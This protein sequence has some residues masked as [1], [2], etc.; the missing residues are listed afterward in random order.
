MKILIVGVGYVGLVTGLCLSEF[1]YQIIFVD[2]NKEKLDNLKKSKC[3]FYE[4]GIDQLLDKHL[5]ETKRINFSSNL[6][7]SMK[8]IDIVFISVGT[9]SRRLEDEADLTS[10]F[11]VSKEIA[12]NINNY[13]VIVT[14]STVPVG[15]T[16]KIKEIISQQI[17]KNKFDV[18]SNP[19]FLREGSAIN[20]FMRPDRVIIGTES[21]KSEEVMKEIYRPLFLKETPII[22]TSIETAEIIKYASNS[23]L[24]TKIAFINEVADLCEVSG[25]NVQDV[26]KAMGLDR[27]IGSK[28]L[29]AG[30]GYGGSCF[31][32]DVKAF[33]STALKAGIKLSIVDAVNNSNKLRPIKIANKISNYYN[34]ELK[35]VVLTLLGLS[36]KPNTDDIRDSTSI[37]IAKE[38]INRG[39]IVNAYDPKA[40]YNAQKEINEIKYFDSAYEACYQSNGLII[41]TEWNEFR[42]LD[43]NKIK[44]ILVKPVI[45]DLRNIYS[46][47][48][49][50]LLGIEYFGI[51]S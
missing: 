51:G 38:L 32:K 1:G 31:P 25:A 35:N 26:A 36:F 21:K 33:S 15:T 9:P 17:N 40:K 49:T 11:E 6:S 29:N 48:E 47:K 28:F 12:S 19:E 24:A 5:N 13:C 27:R 7:N 2:K 14:K 44:K 22:S 34:N 41:A 45:F 10:V 46:K 42:G 18:V 20:D 16:R 23:F 4:P 30:P 39:A 3:P 8:N 43:L 37:I 50:N